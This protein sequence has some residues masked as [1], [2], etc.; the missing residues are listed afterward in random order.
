MRLWLCRI[1]WTQSSFQALH[2]PKSIASLFCARLKIGRLHRIGTKICYWLLKLYQL[3]HRL[4][5]CWQYRLTLMRFSLL[6]ISHNIPIPTH[7]GT[8]IRVMSR[9][10]YIAPRFL[11]LYL[12]R[13]K[14]ASV[15]FNMRI[16]VDD[17]LHGYS[18]VYFFCVQKLL[19]FRVLYSKIGTSY[20]FTCVN[21]FW[22]WTPLITV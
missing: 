3:I 1:L 19:V 17:L 12:F 7:L 13:F 16:P 21:D 8:L 4:L 2:F 9:Q 14:K 15:V 18:V 11:E 5:L 6:I 20:K 10:P 22:S